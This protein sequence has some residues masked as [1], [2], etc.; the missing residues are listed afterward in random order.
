MNLWIPTLDTILQVAGII[1]VLE[2]DESLFRRFG[3]TL[4]C[5]NFRHLREHLFRWL[6]PV[7]SRIRWFWILWIPGEVEL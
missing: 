6:A 7:S 4:K 1:E 3:L 5:P 2:H